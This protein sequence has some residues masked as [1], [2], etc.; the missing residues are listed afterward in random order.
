MN[1]S[2]QHVFDALYARR[3]IRLYRDQPVEQAK[4]VRLLQ[5][6]MAAP[7]AC[8][9]QPW[10][11]VVVSEPEGMARLREVIPENGHYNAPAAI[12]V[13]GCPELIPWD[14]DDGGADC[15][16]AIENMLIAAVAMGLGS[17]WIGGF[18]R[19]AIRALLDIPAQV[20]PIGI[21]YLGYPAEAKEPRTQYLPTAVHWQHYDTARPRDRR[22]GSLLAGKGARGE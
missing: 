13:C 22:P 20:V 21:V 5:A 15:C 19:G 10:E 18:D 8:N 6:A 3:S 12:V 2:E 7:S 11:F 4:L 1:L 17:V 9:I 14:D 16:A